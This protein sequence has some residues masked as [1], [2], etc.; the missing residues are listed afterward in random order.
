MTLWIFW[1]KKRI[2]LKHKNNFYFMLYRKPQPW[3]IFQAIHEFHAD[4]SLIV[5]KRSS[6]FQANFWFLHKN[7]IAFQKETP[8]IGNLRE[9][10][11]MNTEGEVKSPSL[12]LDNIY[13]SWRI[14]E[15][16]VWRC[17]T[18]KLFCHILEASTG[19]FYI[20]IMRFAG[21]TYQA[22][23]RLMKWTTRFTKH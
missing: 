1:L 8:W 3:P 10:C 4:R 12:L 11:L 22:A 19:A 5:L 21:Y 16:I 14:H 17:H 2:D 23:S 18:V 7:W 6:Y 15:H 13:N 20:K 9:Q